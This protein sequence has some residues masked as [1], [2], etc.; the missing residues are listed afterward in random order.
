M[1]MET[2]QDADLMRLA[3]VIDEM[4]IDAGRASSRQRSR[5]HRAEARHCD[6][7]AGGKEHEDGARRPGRAS[8]MEID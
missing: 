3:R 6:S 1:Q 8:E 7:R 2:E 5:R 4:R